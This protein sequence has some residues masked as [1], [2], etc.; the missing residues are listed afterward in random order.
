MT[1]AAAHREP[2]GPPTSRATTS[3]DPP[4]SGRIGDSP[5]RP[6]GVAK[7]T[8]GFTY[9]SD[10][11]LA[12]MLWGTTVRSP[13][14]HAAIRAIDVSAARAVRGVR[15][16]LTAA[17]VPG[18]PGYGLDRA[19]Q[20]VLAADVVRFHG[21]PVALVAADDLSTARRA[22]A[23]VRVDWGVRPAVTDPRTALD[24]ATAP[25]H[26][27]GN[28]VRHVRIR[29][30][31]VQPAGAPAGPGEVVV[32]GEYEVGMQDQAFLGPESG[33]AV[34]AEDGGVDLHVA[35]QWLHADQRQL[36][37]CLDLPPEL[38]RL[39][40]AGVGGAFGGR[41]DLS[42]QVHACM[43]ALRTGR[44]VKMVYSR[45]EAFVGHP[46][47]HPAVL[48]YEH[49]ATVEGR[50]TQVRAEILLDGGAYASSSSAVTANAATLGVGPYDVANVAVDCRAVYTHNPPCGAMRGFGAVQVCFGY[51]SQLDRL[52][53]TVGLDPIEIR[54]RNA[55][56]EG[57]ITPIGQAVDS[58][59]PV[60][61]LLDR[62]QRRPL[63]PPRP[64]TAAGNGG[65]GG[66]LA[67]ADQGLPGGIFASTGADHVVR[68]V[69][70]SVGIKNI[71]F[72]EGFDDYSTVGV[73]LDVAGGEP[74]AQVRTAAAEVGQG[75]VTVLGQIVR[76]ELGV[77]QVAVLPADTSTGDAGSSSASRQTYVTGGAAREACLKVRA[78]LLCRAAD[79]LAA[80]PAGLSLRDGAVVA[81]G[82][83]RGGTAS[84]A[85]SRVSVADLLS[86]GPIDHVVQWRHRPTA[87]LDPWTGQATG[88][89]R[90]HVQFAFA[91]HRAVVDV[92]PEL[93]T[94]RMVE[95][96]CAQDVGRA[97]HPQAVRGQIQGGGV[98][99]MGL[100]LMEEMS[101]QC[102]RVL[103]P[104]FGGYLIPTIMDTPP[105]PVDVLE[106]PDPSAPYG[107]RGV[108]EPPTV[109]AAPAV[110]AAIRAATGRA[111]PRIPIRPEHILGLDEPGPTGGVEGW[112]P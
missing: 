35:T 12:G 37:A 57:A 6:D 104:S 11:A 22:A 58:A 87:P 105:L 98:Q 28:L 38:V 46:H 16:V 43:L 14:V 32:A 4:S 77:R 75:L 97:I 68:G 79:R 81:A 89:G 82:P 19:D 64:T 88:D 90:A 60:A 78:D 102:G 39:T 109:S 42:M 33:L 8:G 70:Y 73:R 91:A 101:I 21:E 86:S 76:S 62:L 72:S 55:M 24:P 29:M 5:V 10:L 112:A 74:F 3:A 9:S 93:G 31:D 92:D 96:Y 107:V 67:A 49:R 95:L 83:A 44:P 34:P 27:D 100:A 52:A 99:G 80:D 41:E 65:G 45:A 7:V 106:L 47:R 94:V 71:C 23:L 56:S 15:A 13:H 110:A 17:D 48:R 66:I 25:V 40:L 36:A 54:R 111:L 63:P 53:A 20:P 61:E 18:R 50:I 26:P 69:G 84:G 108:G 59:A 85:P 51:E 103:D 1:T 2:A 30:G